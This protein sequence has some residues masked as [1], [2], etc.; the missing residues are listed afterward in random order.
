M[1][2]YTIELSEYQGTAGSSN[3]EWYN[4]IQSKV[5]LENGDILQIKQALINTQ[6][7]TNTG[8][9]VEEAGAGNDPYTYRDEVFDGA[10]GGYA[11]SNGIEKTAGIEYSDT[12]WVAVE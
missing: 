11:I 7:S 8:I 1:S 5:V 2:T 4:Q 6:A 3:G 12:P 9:C 10:V